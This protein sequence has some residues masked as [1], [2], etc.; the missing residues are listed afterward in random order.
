MRRVREACQ[1]SRPLSCAKRLRI[2]GF[3][4]PLRKHKAILVELAKFVKPGQYTET[5]GKRDKLAVMGFSLSSF[6]THLAVAENPTIADTAMTAINCNTTGLDLTG[7]VRSYAPRIA[8]LQR[9]S[10]F[11]NVDTGY[12]TWVDAIAQINT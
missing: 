3:T 7:P 11:G 8:S 6:V 10:R 12:L 9:Q 2:L 4:S 5:F 1:S